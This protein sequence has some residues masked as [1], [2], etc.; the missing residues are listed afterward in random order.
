[1]G[2]SGWFCGTTT[3]GMPYDGFSPKSG[4]RLSLPWAWM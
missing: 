3:N 4:C 2:T 1:M